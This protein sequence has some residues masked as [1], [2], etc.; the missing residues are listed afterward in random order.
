LDTFPYSG[1]LTTIEALWMG[2]PTITYPGDR[3]SSRHSMSH[4]CNVGLDDWVVSSLE[5]YVSRAQRTAREH[6]SLAR[7]RETLRNRMRQSPLCDGKRFAT[8]FGSLM[9]SV[10]R[11]NEMREARN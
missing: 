10:W 7:T 3:F 2:V 5:E 1:G 6:D 11:K 8:N 4:L 9:H